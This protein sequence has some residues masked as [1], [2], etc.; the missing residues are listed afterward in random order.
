MYLNFDYFIANVDET[1][2]W[3]LC[4][5]L[6]ISRECCDGGCLSLFDK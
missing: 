3:T 1:F 5:A 2:A 6:I 4:E